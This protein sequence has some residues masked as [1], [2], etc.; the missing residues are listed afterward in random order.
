MI[1]KFSTLFFLLVF[2]CFCVNA[3]YTEVINSNKPGFSE[4]PYSVGQNVYQFESS[5][6]YRKSA[7]SPI[8]SNPESL[9]LKLHFRTSFFDERLEFNLTTALQNDR[10]AFTNVF[11]SSST[12]FTLGELTL[13]AKYLVYKPNYEKKAKEI[14]SWRKRHSFGWDRWIPHVAVYGGI[15]FGSLL[16]EYRNRGSITPKFGVLLQNELSN[17]FNVVTN[18]YYNYI[19]GY[20][21][22]FSYIITGTYNFNQQWSGFAEHQVLINKIEKQSNL[23]LGAAYLF[24]N[25]LQINASVKAIFQEESIGCYLG[26]GVSY[27]IDRHVDNFIELDEYG[28]KIEDI[29][30]QT[31]NKGF[32]GKLVD[33]IKNIFKKKDKNKAEIDPEIS[34]PKTEEEGP[35]TGRGRTKRPKSVLEGIT[36]DDKKEK[37]ATTKAEIKAEKKQLKGEEKAKRA[38]EKE[39]EKEQ[40]K[41]AKEE[42]KRLKEE[43]KL[44]DE[45]KKLE[46]DI[47]KED[48]KAAQEELDRK[49]KEELKK[50]KG[51]KESKQEEL[52]RK[53][54]EELKKKAAEK[55]AA[56]KKKEKEKKENDKDE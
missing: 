6:F 52:D 53:Y 13:A 23:G 39:K 38:I 54:E 11:Q 2:C 18:I 43:K 14:R 5:I 55:K 47:K 46:D 7:A 34:E 41:L 32:F 24:S 21:P 33:K 1:R 44:E 50:K 51:S 12:K 26:L 4:S 28:N 31:Y 35:Q 10:F 40:K 25:D 9:G 37:K 56:E 16:P 30:K 22:E 19:G 3:Q 36:K 8:F 45:I 15:N 20:L 29:E 42:A 27:R 49:Y 48:A 17:Q